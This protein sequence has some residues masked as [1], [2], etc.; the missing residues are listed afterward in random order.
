MAPRSF[1]DDGALG[2]S[3]PG[4]VDPSSPAGAASLGA[5]STTSPNTAS[6]TSSGSND[7]DGTTYS[8]G[9]FGQ[10]TGGDLNNYYN[11]VMSQGAPASET[12]ALQQSYQNTMANQNPDNAKNLAA[13]E[14][15]EGS[16]WASV[17]TNSFDDG[18]AVPEDG[19]GDA[20]GGGSSD[21]I[22][23]ALSSVD[24]AL[25]YGRQKYGLGQSDNTAPLQDGSNYQGGHDY[26]NLHQSPDIEDRRNASPTL[27]ALE[28]PISNTVGS[29]YSLYDRAKNAMGYGE[30][31]DPN[32]QMAN[33]LGAQDVG[34]GA[35]PDEEEQ[36]GE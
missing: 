14:Q 7:W 5:A 3:G 35:I 9:T 34:K 32:D 10:M 16:P 21:I 18:G 23:L 24:K 22:A 8:H 31:P 12:A 36:G 29:A 6:T 25:Q 2:A 15:L 33:E 11:N 30:Q 1:A 28:A 17:Y 26:G 13:V 19:S 27:T 4:T 20:S